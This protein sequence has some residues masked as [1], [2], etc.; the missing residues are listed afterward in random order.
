MSNSKGLKIA[1]VGNILGHGNTYS[2]WTT[3]FI[4]AMS[5]VKNIEMIVVYCPVPNKEEEIILPKKCSIV[6]IID[7]KKPLT[8]FSLPQYIKKEN[9][10][11]VIFIY[12]PTAF[13]SSTL[14]NF[15]GMIIPLIVQK[16]RK[17]KVKIINQGS[18]LTHNSKSLG[19]NSILDRIR[20]YILTFIEKYVYKRVKTYFQLKY[21]CDQIAQ[22]YGKKLVGGMLMS[23]FLDPLT[24]LY[25]NN[26]DDKEYL[27]RS[28]N[29]NQLRLLLHGFWGPQKDPETALIS[30][31]NLKKKIPNLQLTISGG[32][33]NHFPNYQ[34][35]FKELLTK[36][37]DV[38]DNNFEYIKEKDLMELFINNDIVLMPYNASGG[39]SGVLEMGSFFE[40]V[41]VCSDFPEFREEKKSDM[42]VL[43]DLDNFEESLYKSIK[44][45][46]KIP[47]IIC[48]EDKI[49]KVVKNIETFL[50][51]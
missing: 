9:F 31:K 26:A 23:D 22:K 41:V 29:T 36:Y 45:V 20:V 39:Q 38:I 43:T 32:I 49:K 19:Y 5:K 10:D 6:P 24:T 27:T 3:S 35:Y 1:V 47:E 48:V 30:V 16:D 21:Y 25:L 8:L 44:S 15:L 51:D 17:K 18:A 2:E 33:N 28:K 14:S 34:K 4:I 12:G 42:I 46:T 40:N 13:G 50:N 7:Y 11:Q 37:Q